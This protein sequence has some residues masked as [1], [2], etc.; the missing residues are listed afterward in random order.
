MGIVTTKGIEL[1]GYI[2]DK[3][4]RMIMKRNCPNWN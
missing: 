4:L 1:L 3:N 2:E